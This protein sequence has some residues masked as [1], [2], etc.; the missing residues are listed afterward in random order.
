MRILLTANV[1][2]DSKRYSFDKVDV[3]LKAQI[4][5]ILDCG[6]K[7]EDTIL[8]SNVDYEYLGVKAVKTVLN[9]KCR[10][11]SKMFALEFALDNKLYDGIYWAKDLDVWPNYGFDQPEPEIK[12]VGIT[13]YS[14]TKLNGGS[15]FWRP[16]AS[17]IV[18]HV[19]EEI[20][21]GEEKE[22][23]TLNRLLKSKKYAD[24]TTVLNTTYNVGC[25]GFFPRAYMAE[26]PI[27]VCHLNPLN[28]IAWETHRLNRD[29]MNIISVSARLEMVLRRYFD[30]AYRLRSEKDE[31][32]SEELRERHM[33]NLERGKYKK[34]RKVI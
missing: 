18:K 28:R 25:S 17:D 30:L 14:T 10:T 16:S 6:W 32:R 21:K 3:L 27:K 4:E 5:N 8:V 22:E 31:K 20:N 15:V 12:D 11:G 24:R 19:I 13:T 1:K 34:K 26:K 29:G 23:P 9:D 7:S 33:A 2:E